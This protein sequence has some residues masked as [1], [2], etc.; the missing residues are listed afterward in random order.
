[1]RP[2]KARARATLSRRPQTYLR[3]KE[4]STE[5]SPRREASS[6]RIL[7]QGI[8]IDTTTPPPFFLKREREGRTIK[9]GQDSDRPHAYEARGLD[10]RKPNFERK[11]T[12]HAMIREH[13]SI[14]R[15]KDLGGVKTL[16]RGLG[17]Y[18]YD[19]S[20]LTAEPL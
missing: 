16:H 10:R 19:S 13:S 8:E 5:E 11:K 14:K 12:E 9:D 3:L 20:S 6:P 15:T 1:M 17:G 7:S 18:T 2:Y 4:R